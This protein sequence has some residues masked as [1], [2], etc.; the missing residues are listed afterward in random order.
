MEAATTTPPGKAGTGSNKTGKK[1]ESR[2]EAIQLK[3]LRDNLRD[4]LELKKK[5]DDARETLVDKIKAIAKQ[6]G[7]APAVVRT[8]VNAKATDKFEKKARVVEQLAIVFGEIDGGQ[9]EISHA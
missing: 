1:K 2:A 4:L 5:S 7:L 8:L 9:Q 6:A 3:P